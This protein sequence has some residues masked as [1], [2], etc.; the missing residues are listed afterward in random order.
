MHSEIQD[1]E[2]I[3]LNYVRLLNVDTYWNL[4]S[5]SAIRYVDTNP[6]ATDLLCAILLPLI[7]KLC[8]FLCMFVFDNIESSFMACLDSIFI[9]ANHIYCH[10]ELGTGVG[11]ASVCRQVR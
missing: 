10:V 1:G 7:T 9:V 2:S 3:Y 5:V 11:K 6:L 4:S 8:Y